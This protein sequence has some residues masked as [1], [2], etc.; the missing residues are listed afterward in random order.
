MTDLM[1]LSERDRLVRKERQASVGGGFRAPLVSIII[2]TL[3]ERDNVREIVS[4][5]EKVVAGHAWEV[6]FVDD[7]SRDGTLEVLR[8]LSRSD[9][10]VRYLHRIGRRGLASAGPVGHLF[11]PRAFFSR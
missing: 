7:D 6:V 3:N 2:P 1:E 10:R 9:P 8:D 5:V 4:C 11:P